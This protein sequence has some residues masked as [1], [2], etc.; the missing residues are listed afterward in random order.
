MSD[1]FS[2]VTPLD[3]H[4]TANQMHPAFQNKSIFTCTQPPTSAWASPDSRR[5]LVGATVAAEGSVF[6]YSGFSNSKLQILGEG[7]AGRG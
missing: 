7:G 2:G 1:Q 5:M 6:R 3:R 4:T